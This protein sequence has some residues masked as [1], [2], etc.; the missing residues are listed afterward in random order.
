MHWEEP[1]N[2]G[3]NWDGAG[4]THPSNSMPTPYE[5]ITME[6]YM[7]KYV[8]DSYDIQSTNFRQ[9][10]D[11]VPGRM[12]TVKFV[13]Y[14]DATYAVAYHYMRKA[15]AQKLTGYMFYRDNQ[16]ENGPYA[17]TYFTR[18]YK[19]GCQH[20]I[21]EMTLEEIRE[22]GMTNYMFEHHYI[23]DKCGYTYSTESS[24]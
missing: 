19:I 23:C 9:V 10:L 16:E 14:V 15:D 13:N 11:L 1:D 24:G 5:E 3:I 20:N 21:R 12:W 2:T 22:H 18:F 17:Y 4:T 6:E 7:A 8:T